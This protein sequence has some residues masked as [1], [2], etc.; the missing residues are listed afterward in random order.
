MFSLLPKNKNMKMTYLHFV[1][2]TSL[3]HAH[4]PVSYVPADHLCECDDFGIFVVIFHSK[5][6][7]KHFSLFHCQP[8]LF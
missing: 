8:G 7:S 6:K 5:P 1:D 4:S 3:Y 2:V